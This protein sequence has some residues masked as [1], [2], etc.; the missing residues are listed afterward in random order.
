M[1]VSQLFGSKWPWRAACREFSKLTKPELISHQAT[2]LPSFRSELIALIS[3]KSHHW[4]VLNI[5]IN[6]EE[7]KIVLSVI[8]SPKHTDSTSMTEAWYAQKFSSESVESL[9]YRS[10]MPKCGKKRRLH[11][12]NDINIMNQ[13]SAT[14]IAKGYTVETRCWSWWPNRLTDETAP[15]LRCSHCFHCRQYGH[16]RHCCRCHS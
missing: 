15:C 13:F 3:G 14:I 6:L 16:C 4:G 1:H 9:R 11:L 7:A 10:I 8:F 5:C 2:T 12:M